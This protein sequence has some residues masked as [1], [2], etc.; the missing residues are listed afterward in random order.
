[1]ARNDARTTQE[2]LSEPVFFEKALVIQAAQPMFA[3]HA[4][5][6]HE[7]APAV[8]DSLQ[9]EPAGLRQAII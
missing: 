4:Q 7:P 6:G 5:G 8:P 2:P 9:L 1:M 3:R